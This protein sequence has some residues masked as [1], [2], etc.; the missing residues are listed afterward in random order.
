MAEMFIGRSGKQTMTT[1][2]ATDAKNGFGELLEAI[3]R[4]SVRSQAH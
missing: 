3:Q 2:P 1:I 4:I